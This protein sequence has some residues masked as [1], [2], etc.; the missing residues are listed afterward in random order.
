M[1]LA[2]CMCTAGLLTERGTTVCGVLL[3]PGSPAPG[4]CMLQHDC[5]CAACQAHHPGPMHGHGQLPHCC[6]PVTASQA[7]HMQCMATT[8]LNSQA[9]G[10]T[11]PCPDIASRL[12]SAHHKPPKNKSLPPVNWRWVEEGDGYVGRLQPPGQPLGVGLPS[13]LQC[14]V[15]YPY[16][17]L[18]SKANGMH[19]SAT[20]SSLP[21]RVSSTLY[22][23]EASR[24]GSAV[25]AV[26]TVVS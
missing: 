15:L 21:K 26:V 16:R 25:L 24:E 20:T 23:R 8:C 19:S 14:L 3:V 22:S 13:G 17:T 11:G 9:T 5:S 12:E 2:P 6:P 10:S 18:Q 4:T 1:L 7:K